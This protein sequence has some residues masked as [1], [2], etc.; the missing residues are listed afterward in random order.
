MTEIRTATTDDIDIIREL[1]E[2]IWWPT[3]SSILSEAQ[4]QYMLDTIYSR[5]TILAQLKSGE[6]TYILL[7]DDNTPIGFASYGPRMN[8]PD[9]YK[10]HKLYC[11]VHTK[12]KGYGKLLMQAVEQ[13][14]QEAGK[15]VLELNVNRYNPA[16]GFYEKQGFT[17]A[18]EEDIAIGNG[19]WM[20]DYVMRKEL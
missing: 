17:V 5:D 13:A 11:L 14:V 18:Y 3:Y 7:F 9:V 8:E 12:G 19:Y 10:L 1:A 2:S 6:Q 4:L 16:K 20:N 15:S